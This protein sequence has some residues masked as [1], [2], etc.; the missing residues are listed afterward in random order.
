MLLCAC[1]AV[2]H[3]CTH[4]RSNIRPDVL[5]DVV[6]VFVSDARSDGV[7]YL[8]THARPDICSI[9]KSNGGA[10]LRPDWKANLRADVFSDILSV[11]FSNT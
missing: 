4:G 7:S 5:P 3:V 9:R 10:H 1:N 11:F 2:A 8:H 6:S